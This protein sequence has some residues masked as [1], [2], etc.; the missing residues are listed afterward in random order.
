MFESQSERKRARGGFS[1]VLRNKR[2]IKLLE[3]LD[4]LHSLY[5]PTKQGRQTKS[6]QACREMEG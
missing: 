5:P 2:Y 1:L 4:F 3:I 6:K